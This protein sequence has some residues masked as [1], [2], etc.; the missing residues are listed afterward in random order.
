MFLSPIGPAHT[1]EKWSHGP[2]NKACV[3]AHL[4]I[5]QVS[6]WD[7]TQSIGCQ[8]HLAISSAIL[9]SRMSPTELGWC[10]N[11]TLATFY[12]PFFIEAIFPNN[13]YK[14]VNVPR[15]HRTRLSQ[16]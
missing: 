4:S 2:A 16:A 6:N 9:S 12:I 10:W 11:P 3:Q 8:S 15:P 14:V 13:P 5:S 7:R 1:R